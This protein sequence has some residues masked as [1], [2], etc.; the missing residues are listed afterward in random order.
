MLRSVADLEGFVVAASDGEA[1][2][3]A[4]V[5]FD[6]RDAAIIA[7]AADIGSL[8]TGRT[9]LIEPTAVERVD[10]DKRR[11]FVK[12][13][14]HALKHC[15]DIDDDPPVHRRRERRAM[16]TAL[17]LPGRTGALWPSLG[18]PPPLGQPEIGL[19]MDAGRQQLID[20]ID[21]ERREDCHLR[22]CRE[23]IGYDAVAKDGTAVGRIGDVL[24]GLDLRHLQDLVVSIERAE[25]EPPVAVLLPV[26]TA[27]A[28]SWAGRIVRFTMSDEEIR[29]APRFDREQIVSGSKTNDR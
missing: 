7:L 27:D 22:S 15:P 10:V 20:A 2:H 4:D 21:T 18:S 26:A 8:L 5:L 19:A 3:I 9:V 23:I 16:L 1:G 6:D 28:Y 24:L 12:L 17:S 11:C 29:A 25:E 13:D 14:R